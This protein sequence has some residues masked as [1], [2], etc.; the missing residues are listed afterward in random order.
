MSASFDA[1][2]SGPSPHALLEQLRKDSLSV[3]KIDKVIK[4]K[5][6]AM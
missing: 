3:D 4:K 6:S 2:V 5:I 1:D